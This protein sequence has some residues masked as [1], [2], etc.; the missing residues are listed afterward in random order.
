LHGHEKKI[1]QIVE[2]YRG[3]SEYATKVSADTDIKREYSEVSIVFEKNDL[4]L[5]KNKI[6]RKYGG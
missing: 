6:N 1:D 5:L 2:R 3:D 4:V